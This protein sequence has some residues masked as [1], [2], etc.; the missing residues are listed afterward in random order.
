MH[1]SIT[2]LLFYANTDEKSKI[3]DG[4]GNQKESRKL[5]NLGEG[6]ETWRY[7]STVISIPFIRIEFPANSR[8]LQIY[9]SNCFLRSWWMSSMKD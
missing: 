1:F 7:A 5:G 6:D 9:N 8:G 3:L 2:P 4:F